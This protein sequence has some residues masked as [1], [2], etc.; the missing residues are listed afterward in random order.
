M[1]VFVRVRMRLKML[2][3]IE[4]RIYKIHERRLLDREVDTTVLANKITI[5]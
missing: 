2:R 5:T 4:R 3:E 1:S